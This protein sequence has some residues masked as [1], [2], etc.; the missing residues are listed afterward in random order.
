V[1]GAQAKPWALRA[2][3]A[4]HR[5]ALL[6]LL[7]DPVGTSLP[8]PTRAHLDLCGACRVELADT[9]L[10]GFA[11]RRSLTVPP[12]GLPPADA[13]P[14]LRDRLWRRQRAPTIGRASSPVA[15]LALAAGLAVA[16]LAPLGLPVSGGYAIHEAGIDPAA[17]QAAGHRDAEAEARLQRATEL[18]GK[19]ARSEDDN[20]RARA[21]LIRFEVAPVPVWHAP[22]R[23]PLVASAR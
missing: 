5:A 20:G 6:D 15:G 23:S 7:E 2:D 21:E 1:I 19:E 17:I 4:R 9:L 13:W 18:A 22:S 8:A 12:E 3:C 11:V 14:R 16:M 10:M